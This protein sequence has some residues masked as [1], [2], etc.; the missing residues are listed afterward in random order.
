MSTVDLYEYNCYTENMKNI[1]FCMSLLSV[2]AAP[3]NIEGLMNCGKKLEAIAVLHNQIKQN[4]NAIRDINS[5]DNFSLDDDFI[6]D[7]EGLE[8]KP[9]EDLCK[10][11]EESWQKISS[12]ENEV[13]GFIENN[14][15]I[16]GIYRLKDFSDKEDSVVLSAE[17]E[18]LIESMQIKI[19]GEVKKDRDSKQRAIRAL[20]RQALNDVWGT[21]SRSYLN[22]YYK[23]EYNSLGY[24]YLIFKQ[25]QEFTQRKVDFFK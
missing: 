25:F 6:E 10:A 24:P 3:F 1:I 4:N 18:Q 5:K 20:M 7:D 16:A 17:Q 13:R 23:E 15:D 12:L 22:F 9:R 14:S 2:S 8:N 19:N 11:N 21:H